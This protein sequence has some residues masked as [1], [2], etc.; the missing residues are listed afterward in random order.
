MNFEEWKILVKG[1]KCAF[2][3]ER[4]LPDADSVKVWYQ[5][6]QDLP[7]DLANLSVQ[8]HILTNHFPPTIADIR[9]AAAEISL[10]QSPDW[11]EGWQQVLKAIRNYGVWRQEDALNSMDPIT[12]KCVERLGFQN[13]CLSKEINQDRANFRMIYEQTQKR[14]LENKKIPEKIKKMI[15]KINQERQMIDGN[16]NDSVML[17]QD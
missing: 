1:L 8:K 16:D 15:E 7:Y 5:L 13:I 17:S 2:P 3:S 11:S 14:E 12:R 6:L 9:E 10:A 4:L